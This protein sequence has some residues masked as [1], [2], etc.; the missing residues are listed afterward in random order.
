M[1]VVVIG[2]MQH[3]IGEFDAR[4]PSYITISDV[5]SPGSFE[6]S[7]SVVHEFTH[8]LQWLSGELR[9][10]ADCL[11]HAKLEMEAYKT[12]E[13]WAIEQGVNRDYSGKYRQL[14][15]MCVP[16]WQ[17]WGFHPSDFQCEAAV[18]V[19]YSS[20]LT[21]EQWMEVVVDAETRGQITVEHGTRLKSLIHE[22]YLSEDKS[23]FIES[24]C[25]P[26]R[27]I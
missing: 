18:I 19:H 11:S 14:Q 12:D 17:R 5:L 10:L 7:D 9:P 4:N 8:Y 21:E 20:T 27:T 16:T 15:G 3:N 6:W 23:K 24:N 22:A 1:P 26:P 25:P 13:R 2:P